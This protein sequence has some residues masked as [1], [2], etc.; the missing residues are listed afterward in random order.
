MRWYRQVVGDGITLVLALEFIVPGHGLVRH[1]L[2]GVGHGREVEGALFVVI[3]GEERINVLENHTGGVDLLL[4][5]EDF[6]HLRQGAGNL[7]GL[8]LE[9]GE[10]LQL[11]LVFLFEELQLSL[12]ASLDR[13]EAAGGEVFD[14]G[15][16]ERDD[17]V[18]R[19]DGAV[20]VECLLV[21]GGAIGLGAE[22]GLVEE[23]FAEL[24]IRLVDQR[25]VLLVID[26]AAQEGDGFWYRLKALARSPLG[27]L[28]SMLPWVA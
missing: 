20:G 5:E 4:A 26:D 23:D 18:L 25:D 3:R 21:E 13:L 24:E 16:L 19:G 9:L 27:L 11:P 2:E 10:F 1:T 8:A 7:I 15:L 28:S 12:I 22:G 14:L 17:R 6:A